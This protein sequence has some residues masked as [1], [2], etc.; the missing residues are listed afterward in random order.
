MKIAIPDDIHGNIEALKTTYNAALSRN[1][2]IMAMFNATIT[3]L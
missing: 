1:R 2:A 3:L